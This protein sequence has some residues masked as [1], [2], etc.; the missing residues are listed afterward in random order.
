MKLVDLTNNKLGLTNKELDY[1]S[2]VQ[3]LNINNPYFIN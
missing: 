2:S 3:S 1:I